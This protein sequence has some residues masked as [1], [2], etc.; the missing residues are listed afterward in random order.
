MKALIGAP[1]SWNSSPQP[2]NTSPRPA[3]EA[4]TKGTSAISMKPAVMVSSLNG[5]GVVPARKIT[6][7]SYFFSWQAASGKLSARPRA[8]ST[9]WPTAS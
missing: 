1:N 3:I 7:Q 4:S 8:A 6:S 2:M 5:I 9:A